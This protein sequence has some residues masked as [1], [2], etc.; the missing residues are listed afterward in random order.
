LIH[1]QAASGH[2]LTQ[3]K[4]DSAA[5]GQSLECPPEIIIH[6]IKLSDPFLRQSGRGETEKPDRD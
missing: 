4:P 2:R 1:D 3:V 6:S 5:G